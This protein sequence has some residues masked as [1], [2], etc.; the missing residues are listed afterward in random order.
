MPMKPGKSQKVVS[1]NIREMMASQKPAAAM[2]KAGKRKPGPGK[3]YRTMKSLLG[4][5]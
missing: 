4:G 1:E 2:K 3:G 5:R